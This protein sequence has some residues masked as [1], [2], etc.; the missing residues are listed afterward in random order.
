MTITSKQLVKWHDA[1]AALML[2][3]G[4][5]RN[6]SIGEMFRAIQ[7]LRAQEAKG[8]DSLLIR[9]LFSHIGVQY[10][11]HGGLY[12]LNRT[13]PVLHRRRNEMGL[14]AMTDGQALAHG[15]SVTTVVKQGDEDG[16][17]RQ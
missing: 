2:E 6:E 14:A 13:L 1:M 8:E 3:L 12:E 17:N 15:I 9:A 16:S 5:S 11:R 4:Q 7:E 10:R